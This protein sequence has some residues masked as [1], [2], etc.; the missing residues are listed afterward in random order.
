MTYRSAF[1]PFVFLSGWGS[2]AR[3]WEE[4]YHI[5]C[6]SCYTPPKVSK[7]NVKRGFQYNVFIRLS[8]CTALA[9]MPPLR[10][11]ECLLLS[12]ECQRPGYFSVGCSPKEC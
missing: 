6:F 3:F 2:C 9:I 10:R 8:A 12:R 7:D 11:Q 5:L 1:G 4:N